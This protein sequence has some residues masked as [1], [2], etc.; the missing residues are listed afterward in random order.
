MDDG[1]GSP[2]SAVCIRFSIME[3]RRHWHGYVSQLLVIRM[4][5]HHHISHS[6]SLSSSSWIDCAALVLRELVLLDPL[7]TWLPLLLETGDLDLFEPV[8]LAGEAS[9]PF[10]LVS[11]GDSLLSPPPL[12]RFDTLRLLLSEQA[13]SPTGKWSFHAVLQDGQTVVLGEK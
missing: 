11:S 6:Y 8:L 7:S 4:T 13:S 10:L 9:A 12:C 3:L 2:L 1:V 5:S